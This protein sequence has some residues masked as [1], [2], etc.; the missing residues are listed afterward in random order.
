MT[1]AINEKKRERFL[2]VFHGLSLRML[3]DAVSGML[4]VSTIILQVA[5][6]RQFQR[7]VFTG[8]MPSRREALPGSD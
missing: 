3:S 6:W 7:F 5:S 1:T 2:S 4:L 8:S